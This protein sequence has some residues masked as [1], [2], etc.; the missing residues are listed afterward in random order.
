MNN[1]WQHTRANRFF[2]YID[3]SDRLKLVH[4][5]QIAGDTD[6]K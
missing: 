4:M 3:P 1:L 5:Q 2:L 6:K